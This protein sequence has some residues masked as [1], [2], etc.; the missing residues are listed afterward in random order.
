MKLRKPLQM[1]NVL[2]AWGKV[3]RGYAP[4]LSIELTRECPLNCPGCYA[5]GDEHLGGGITLRQLRDKRGE[6]L[7]KGV[8]DL[9]KR[10]RPVQVSFIGGE[11]LVRHRELSR[12]LPAL[13][14]QGISSL[15]ITSLIIP[16]PEEWNRL[17][18][19]RVSVSVDGLAEDHDKR[20]AP[21]TYDRILKHMKNRKVEISW[22]VTNQQAAQP[23][24]L[25]EYLKFWTSRPEVQRV[26]LSLYTPQ[27]G[28]QSE[29]ML[30]PE[31]RSRVIR[32]LPEL[33]QKYPQLVLPPGA[34][35][36]FADPPH[37][38]QQC[39]FTR[40]S[41]N[42]SADLKTEVTPC[43]FGG[44]PD[45]SQCG[46]AI[47]ASLHFLHQKP[48]LGGLK[49]GHIIDASLAVGRVMGKRGKKQ[50]SPVTSTTDAVK[51]T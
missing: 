39:T 2:S 36:A 12:I 21:A 15:V 3:L 28:E 48:L 7:V 10:H 33:K 19:V 41:Q 44:N 20:R 25:D 45:C 16:F 31:N 46:C 6:E 13:S 29:E 14:R 37:S 8:L 32:E 23:G 51:A 47:S 34:E 9:I 17:W 5:Y 42:F 11:P 26:W 27:K 40:I 30:T 22:V 50:K 38:P 18:K 49:G 4:L 35:Q 43:F 24:Y 1:Q